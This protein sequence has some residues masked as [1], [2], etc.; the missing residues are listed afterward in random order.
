MPKVSQ[1][2]L[3]TMLEKGMSDTQIAAAS[4][5]TRQAVSKRRRRLET[6]RGWGSPPPAEVSAPPTA[7]DATDK[8]ILHRILGQLAGLAYERELNED[9]L[10]RI[11]DAQRDVI[12]AFGYPRP[13]Y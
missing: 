13:A 11:Y 4:G 10:D 3:L 5:I 1:A 8:Q 12:E 6:M 7:A 2:V 9:A